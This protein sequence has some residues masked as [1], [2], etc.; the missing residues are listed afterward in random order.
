[1]EISEL[2]IAAIIVVTLMTLGLTILTSVVDR[3]FSDQSLELNLSEQ[4]FRQL[5][6]S[7]QVILWRRSLDSSQFSFVNKEAEELLGFRP[8][9]WLA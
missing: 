2:G 5:V 6:E 1:V 8:E 7:A 9:Q 3:R 4:R